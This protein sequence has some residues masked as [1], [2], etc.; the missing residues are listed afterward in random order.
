MIPLIGKNGSEQPTKAKFLYCGYMKDVG[1]NIRR[2]GQ[3]F[4]V[5]EFATKYLGRGKGEKDVMEYTP[6]KPN[7][8]IPGTNRVN[9]LNQV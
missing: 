8:A 5:H 3:G 1:V 7:K 2:P 9:L 4:E 6:S